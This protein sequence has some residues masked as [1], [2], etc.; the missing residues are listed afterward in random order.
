MSIIVE[1][2][3][4]TKRFGAATV[5][6][7][8]SV[9]VDAG[10]R[11]GLIG[12]NGSGKTTLARILAGLD[13]EYEGRC[14]RSPGTAVAYVPQ[15]L[16]AAPETTCLDYM[17]RELEPLRLELRRC[18]EQLAAVSAA[19]PRAVER[20]LA[21]Y[22]RARDA[23]E[24]AGGDEASGSAEA[25]LDAVGL[26]GRAGSPV[27]VLSGGEQNV[28][29]LAKAVARRPDLL[30]L[31]EPGNHLDFDGLEWLERFIVGFPGAVL[32]ISHNR[33]LLDRTTS[34]TAEVADRAVMRYEGN[35]SAYRLA[36][37]RAATAQQADYAADAKKLARLEALVAKF[38]QI[39]REHADPAWGRRLRA[40]R[41]QLEHARKAAVDRPVLT[42]RSMDVTLGPGQSRAE[43]AVELRGYSRAFGDLVLFDRADALVRCGERVAVVGPNGS[44]KTTLLRD[45]VERGSWDDPHVRVGPSM[46]VGYCSQHQDI[47]RP[48]ATILEEML[49]F[50]VKNAADAIRL[51]GRYLFTYEDLSARIGTLSGGERNR[52]QFAACELAGANILVLDEPTN[53]MDIASRE[54]IEDALEEFAGTVILV[55]HD[56]YLIDAVASRVLEIVDRSLA[57]Y[58]GSYTEYRAM[59]RSSPA[60]AHT[61]RRERSTGGDRGTRGVRAGG[62][63]GANGSR[64]QDIERRI[65]RLEGEKVALERR[66]TEAF[67]RSD[68]RGGRKLANELEQRA[69]ELDAAWETWA[70]LAE[71]E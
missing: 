70:Q 68:H 57:G 6:E 53:H 31:D 69:R 4:V 34:A 30:I 61:R 64:L 5:L 19:D 36:K 52:L 26:P 29:C 71:E 23:F 54:A 21:E 39:A 42:A 44:G 25:A 43:I 10:E 56:R 12:V 65:S 63:S 24:A 47:F 33:Y 28:L 48:E 1:A 50:G 41:T 66:I 14:H 3:G 7:N 60:R 58:N 18:E 9:R 46:Q 40:R 20:A 27:G 8:V 55:S 51:L 49:R 32:I 38:A 59:R 11:I 13:P 16:D 62:A 35:Y 45:I 17:T 22:Q 67:E 2:N 37:L 15:Y